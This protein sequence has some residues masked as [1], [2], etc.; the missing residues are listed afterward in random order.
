MHYQAEYDWLIVV[1]VHEIVEDLPQS[2]LFVDQIEKAG[3]GGN[4]LVFLVKDSLL[5]SD[6]LPGGEFTFTFVLS[7]SRLEKTGDGQFRFMP[8]KGV[9]I[10]NPDKHCWE[11]AF[12]YIYT[13]FKARRRMLLT[14]SHGAGLGINGDPGSVIRPGTNKVISNPYYF[15]DGQDVYT[16]TGPS[17]DGIDRSSLKDIERGII[18]KERAGKACRSLEI[19]WIS[20]L[21]DALFRCLG[22]RPIDILLMVNCYMQLFDAGFMLSKKVRYLVAPEGSILAPGYDY[23]RLFALLGQSPAPSERDIVAAIVED[24]KA[25]SIG[26]GDH[27]TSLFA[28]SLE[29]YPRLLA[30]FK[31]FVGL[32]IAD[33]DRLFPLLAEIRDKK[34]AYVSIAG[35]NRS[36]QSQDLID[37]GQWIRLVAAST[38]ASPRLSDLYAE[39]E[40]L[41]GVLVQARFVGSGYTDFDRDFEPKFGYSGISIYYPLT[42]VPSGH[43]AAGWCDYFD[44]KA[45]DDFRSGSNW[46]IFLE[47]YFALRTANGK[48]N[49]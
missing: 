40:E 36:A 18:R 32:V 19:L 47:N 9:P 38:P 30:V 39:F 13:Q 41:L 5:R 43:P 26:L 29:S 7:L 14:L 4:N 6:P 12:R 1:F 44:G 17:F 35:N 28:N 15:L 21:R 11:A 37:L 16:L 25:Q 20:G 46:D 8:V 31:E 24:Y 48:A 45:R 33:I 2:R 27:F 34:V 3:H 22:D 23:G 49:E 10:H 42:R